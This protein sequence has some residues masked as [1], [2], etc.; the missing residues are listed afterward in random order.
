[1]K[2]AVNILP[3]ADPDDRHSLLRV[4]NLKENSVVARSHTPGFVVALQSF[5]SSRTRVGTQR[6]N[7]LLDGFKCR[8]WDAFHLFL[9]CIGD[10]YGVGH[11]RLRR[12]S[13]IACSKGMG[14]S[15]EALASSYS[16]TAC[17]SSR[18]SISSSYSWML[19]TTAILSPFSFVRNWV[20]SFMVL[21]Y[22]KFTPA[23]LRGQ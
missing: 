3:M 17:K 4:V 15:P 14:F 20:G 16:R 11:L 6:K 12:I 18:S 10:E 1:M 22:E 23:L 7:L 21:P 13:D 19:M 8:R 9:R 2:L 5:A